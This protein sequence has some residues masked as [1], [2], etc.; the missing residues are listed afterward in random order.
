MPVAFNSDS[1]RAICATLR[2]RS[3]A[4]IRC[5]R[6]V[7]RDSFEQGDRDLEFVRDRV[8]RGVRQWWHRSLWLGGGSSWL[9]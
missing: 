6:A 1:S 9:L 2:A 7:C 5:R 4:F 3:A 8:V